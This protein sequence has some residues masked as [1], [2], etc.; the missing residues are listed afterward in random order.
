MRRPA[1]KANSREAFAAVFEQ[2]TRRF[3]AFELLG[4]ATEPSSE[5]Q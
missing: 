5:T 2:Q 1:K 3:S 4:L